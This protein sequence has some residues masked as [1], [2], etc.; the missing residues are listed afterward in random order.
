MANREGLARIATETLEIAER[1]SYELH[2]GATVSIGAAQVEA[3]AGTAMY[4]PD[5]LRALAGDVGTGD[6]VDGAATT[7]EVQNC[8]TFAGAKLLLADHADADV[9]CLNFASARN[10]GG[11]FLAGSQAQEEALCRA[12]GLYPCLLTQPEYYEVNRANRSALYTDH[13]IYSPRVPVFRDDADQLIAEPYAVSIVTAPAP[14][15]GAIRQND[16]DAAS[17]IGETMRRRIGAVL[18]V[19]ADR[20]HHHLVLGAWGC[21]VFGNDPGEV[22]DLFREAL[23]SRPFAGAFSRVLFAVLDFSGELHTF[24]PFHKT[25]SI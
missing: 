13:I 21:G 25:L 5:D 16:P 2:G 6:R 23:T 4:R 17:D 11:G 7:I 1:G 9:L 22:A 8:T 12:S 24:G 18:T 10:P 19:A 14:N 20:G 3:M 15:A